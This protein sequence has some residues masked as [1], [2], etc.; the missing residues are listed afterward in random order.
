M[1]VFRVRGHLLL[2]N[3]RGIRSVNDELFVGGLASLM[4]V[5][6]FLFAIGPWNQPYRLRSTAAITEKY[7]KPFARLFW[8]ALALAL[9]A[10]GV[11][12]MLGWRPSYTSPQASRFFQ[13]VTPSSA[14][15]PQKNGKAVSLVNPRS[16]DRFLL[17]RGGEETPRFSVAN[18]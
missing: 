15:F 4:A 10:V 5:L 1:C 16:R 13:A 17:I 2:T 11:A 12:I 18:G 6:C 9:S 3:L 7:G 8:L 14:S